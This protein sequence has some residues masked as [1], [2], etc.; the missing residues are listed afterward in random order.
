MSKTKISKCLVCGGRHTAMSGKCPFVEEA[1]AKARVKTK[2]KRI[3]EEVEIEHPA[4]EQT[5]EP[6]TMCEI[7]EKIALEQQ[8]FSELELMISKTREMKFV[9]NRIDRF[10]EIVSH[11]ETLGHE[12][13]D[14]RTTYGMEENEEDE[15]ILLCSTLQS[16][17]ED[18]ELSKRDELPDDVKRL[19]DNFHRMDMRDML[20]LCEANLRNLPLQ[21]R[22]LGWD[23]CYICGMALG[24]IRHTV[25]L[26]TCLKMYDF[27]GPLQTFKRAIW[28]WE[29]LRDVECLN[30][31]V[32]ISPK[33]IWRKKE[34]IDKILELFSQ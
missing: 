28:F 23:I 24:Y 18:V 13:Q 19:R 21:S 30:H 14:L 5:S 17:I 8:I 4:I 32:N 33:M 15:I 6:I 25:G 10:E 9:I 1:K 3:I 7:E 27:L 31:C 34:T 22:T 16:H 29:L 26:E 11:I 20:L 12:I 2:E